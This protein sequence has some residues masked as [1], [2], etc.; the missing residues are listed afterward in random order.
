[1]PLPVRGHTATE[2]GALPDPGD[3]VPRATGTGYGGPGAAGSGYGGPLSP[4]AGPRT[5]NTFKE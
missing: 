2:P 3:G 1:A 4:Q 5:E